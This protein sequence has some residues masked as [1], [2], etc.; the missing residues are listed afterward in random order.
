MQA[1]WRAVRTQKMRTQRSRTRKRVFTATRR[2]H[3]HTAVFTPIPGFSRFSRFFTYIHG[4]FTSICTHFHVR[5]LVFTFISCFH[6]HALFSRTHRHFRVHLAKRTLDTF[7]VSKWSAR[8]RPTPPRYL[9]T[10][11]DIELDRDIDKYIEV[12]RHRETSIQFIDVARH[13]ETSIKFIDVARHRETSIKFIDVARH[14]ETSIK[15]IDV[16]RHR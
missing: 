1:S 3:V 7:F 6:A 2:F 5:I 13:R 8:L 16:A 15:F 9:S 14:R 4:F 12:A 10:S 11:R